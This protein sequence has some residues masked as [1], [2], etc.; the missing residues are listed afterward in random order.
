MTGCPRSTTGRLYDGPGSTTGPAL[1]RVRLHDGAPLYD[2]PPL[3]DKPPL[4]DEPPR[5]DRVGSKLQPPQP[6]QRPPTPGKGRKGLRLGKSGSVG[7][8]GRR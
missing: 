6:R 1:R 7:G 3:H 5:N 2:G 4:H 8:G